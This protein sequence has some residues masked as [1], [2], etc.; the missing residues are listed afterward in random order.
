MGVYDLPPRVIPQVEGGTADRVFR[1][2]TVTFEHL[3]LWSVDALFRRVHLELG[4]P[5]VDEVEAELII[6]Y[7]G[8]DEERFALLDSLADRLWT[9]PRFEVT[10]ERIKKVGS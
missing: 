2:T 10:R 7:I 3:P 4:M 1:D 8:L 5:N 6:K 9:F